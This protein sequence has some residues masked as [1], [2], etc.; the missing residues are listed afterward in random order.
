MSRRARFLLRKT[1]TSPEGKHIIGFGFTVGWWPCLRAPFIRLSAG[2]FI[3]EVW[4]GA[5]SYRC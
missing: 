4:Y 5:A 2:N 3:I 1:N